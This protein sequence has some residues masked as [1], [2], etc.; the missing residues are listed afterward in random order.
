MRVPLS[1]EPGTLAGFGSWKPG[2]H[3]QLSVKRVRVM[4]WNTAQHVREGGIFEK[5]NRL[6]S[7]YNTQAFSRDYCYEVGSFCHI[8]NNY[9]YLLRT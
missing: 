4:I 9:S 3:P 2:T 1:Q 8:E 7:F 5:Q 6:F